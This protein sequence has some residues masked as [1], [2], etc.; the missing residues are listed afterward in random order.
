MSEESGKLRTGGG[1]VWR[2]CLLAV[3]VV[4]IFA[5][6]A[7]HKAGTPVQ[8]E[9]GTGVI[10]V[11]PAGAGVGQISRLLADNQL[12]RSRIYFRALAKIKG[13]EGKMQAGEFNLSPN[14]STEQIMMKI[15]RGEVVAYPVTLPEGLT[16]KQIAR[17]LAEKGFVDQAKFLALVREDGLTTLV[18]PT[19]EVMEPLEGFLFPDTYFLHKGMTEAEIIQLLLRRFREVMVPQ[20]EERAR[21]LGLT[22]PELITIASMIERE[23]QVAAERSIIAGVI[24]NRLRAG[25]ALQIDATV[26]YLLPENTRVVLLK[27]LEIDSPY[28]TYQY[29]GLPPGPIANPGREAIA[30]ALYPAETPYF[31]YVAKQDGSHIFSRTLAEHNRAIR[32]ARG[33]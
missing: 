17:V 21:E 31:Y 15:A 2:R 26:L 16:V 33:R 28:N 19:A 4:A 6:L 30:A 12:I 3:L 27:D 20:W 22:V 1:R 29:P 13:V 7:V 5:A 14:L 25:M 23:A 10:I 32:I 9:P 24:Y 8:P 11:I 18:T